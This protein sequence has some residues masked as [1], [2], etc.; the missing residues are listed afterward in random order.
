MPGVWMTAN[1]Y[2]PDTPG[3]TRGRSSPSTATGA[4]RSRTRWCSPAASARRSSGS[5]CSCVDAFGAGER[6][7][8]KA[9]GEYHGEMTAAT[10]LPVRVRRCRACRSTRTA[11]PSITSARGPRSTPTGSASPGP[12]AA[13]TRRCTPARWIDGLKA[14]VPV[15]SVGNYQAYLGTACCMCEVVP[16]ALTFTEEWG[17]LGLVAPKGLMVVNATR[18]ARP[19]LRRRGEED[20][21]GPGRRSIELYEPPDHLRHAVFE[22]GHDYSQAMREAMYGWMTRHLKGE[23]DGAPIAEPAIKTEDPETLRCYPGDT[24]PDDFVTIPRFAAAEGRK[25]LAAK[26][27]PADA[28]SWKREAE[29]LRKTLVT[30]TLGGFPEVPKGSGPEVDRAGDGT[31]RVQSGTGDQPLGPGRARNRARR[32]RAVLIDLD[33]IDRPDEQ[34]PRGRTPARRLGR[35]DDRTSR[36]RQ[37][38]LAVRQGRPRPRPQHGRVGPLDRPPD[39]GPVGLRRPPSPRRPRSVRQGPSARDGP[40]RRRPRRPRRARRGGDRPARH[41]GRGGRHARQLRLGR[42][43]SRASDSASSPPGSSRTSATS[44]TSPRSSPRAGW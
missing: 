20:R 39:A 43:I 29:A 27:D 25:L 6:G 33:G 13:A 36:H 21:R 11:G 32:A 42:T 9:L 41:E 30:K 7:V 22:S 24:R 16:G 17:V 8:G 19:V 26:A 18:D 5:S 23:G 2:V 1:V 10:L 14:V 35:R 37:A 34:P 4:G 12:A 15:C 44:P 3:K 28:A 31:L 38:R 40:D